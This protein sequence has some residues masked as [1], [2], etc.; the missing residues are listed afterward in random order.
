M[1][2]ELC[3]E[4][5]A[6]IFSLIDENVSNIIAL[7]TTTWIKWAG[8]DAF[9]LR[10]KRPIHPNVVFLHTKVFLRKLGMHHFKVFPDIASQY[11]K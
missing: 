6:R 9:L 10:S 3:G 1:K 8:L 5:A 4:I 11:W 2:G 7:L